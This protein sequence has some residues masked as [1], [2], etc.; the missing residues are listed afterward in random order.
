M[1]KIFWILLGVALSAI[2][3]PCAH[4]DSVT[5]VTPSGSTSG[6]QP[7]DAW[8]TFVTGHGTVAVTLTD[9]EVNPTSVGQLISDLDFVL[10][11]GST[12][13]FL[14]SSSGP[15]IFRRHVRAWLYR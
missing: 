7:V 5:F 10:S 8:A 2:M 1:R 15:E 12:V 3:T 13:A 9:L 4:A 6:G 11:N 14:A